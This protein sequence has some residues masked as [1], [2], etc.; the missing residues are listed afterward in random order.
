MS[1]KSC[2]QHIDL[3]QYEYLDVY[4]YKGVP[5]QVIRERE[6]ERKLKPNSR[7]TLLLGDFGP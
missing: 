7:F 1:K 5:E 6:F 4:L 3:D 2:R